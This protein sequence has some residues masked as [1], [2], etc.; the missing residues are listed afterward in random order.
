[1]LSLTSSLNNCQESKVFQDCKVSNLELQCWTAS[2]NFYHTYVN[3]TKISFLMVTEVFWGTNEIICEL[4]TI[5]TSFLPWWKATLLLY[6]SSKEPICY[7]LLNQ[8][9]V[10]QTSVPP[11]IGLSY[12][13]GSPTINST[14]LHSVLKVHFL[15]KNYK[16]LKSLN[17]GQFLFLCQSI[18]TQCALQFTA[19]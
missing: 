13:Y 1:M 11:K 16:F 12:L 2:K 4:W 8:M 18:W 7:S 6:K 5:W 17:N 3:P 19:G 15:Y 10:C 9:P 14:L